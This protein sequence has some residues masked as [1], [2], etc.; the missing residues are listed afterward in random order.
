[1]RIK[2]VLRDTDILQLEAGSKARIVAVA[3]KNL[4]RVMNLPSFLKVIGLRFDERCVML[5]ALKDS[6]IH[7]WLLNDTQQH[8]IYLSEKSESTFGGYNWQ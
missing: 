7:V 4:E 3:K 8:L 1:M 6:G 5:E 2:A